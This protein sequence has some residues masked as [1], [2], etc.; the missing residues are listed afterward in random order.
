LAFAPTPFTNSFLWAHSA[1]FCLLPIPYN[2]NRL[3]TS[4]SKLPWTRLLSLWHF[5]LLSRLVDYYFYYLSLMVFFILL[6]LLP[7]PF[8]Y[9]GLFLVIGLFCQ[10]GHQQWQTN[11]YTI[12]SQYSSNLIQIDD[13]FYKNNLG[14]FIFIVSSTN[15][16]AFDA[17]YPLRLHKLFFNT[18]FVEI[19]RSF[20]YFFLF[21]IVVILT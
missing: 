12:Y 5:L 6:A 2:F 8:S 19:L 14:L 11:I 16:N 13:I 10:S 3:T 7:L 9:V 18:Y 20:F 17:F 21:F 1:H 15:V 4:F